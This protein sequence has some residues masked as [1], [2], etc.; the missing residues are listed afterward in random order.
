MVVS[1]LSDSEYVLRCFFEDENIR[2][3]IVDKMK[4]EYFDDKGDKQLV[5]LINMFAKKYKRYPSAQELITGLNQNA[6]Y[7]EDAKAKLLRITKDIG[8]IDP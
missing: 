8:H 1:D 7:G 6:G 3:H 5:S 4:E 2:L